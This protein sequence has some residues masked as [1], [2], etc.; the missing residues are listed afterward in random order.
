MKCELILPR[1]EMRGEMTKYWF[2]QTLSMNNL[3]T[4]SSVMI[5]NKIVLNNKLI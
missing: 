3:N 2:Y 1:N 4:K 5:E